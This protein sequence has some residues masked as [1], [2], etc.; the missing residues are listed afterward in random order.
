[1]SVRICIS[2]CDQDVLSALESALNDHGYSVQNGVDVQCDVAVIV[3]Q[4]WSHKECLERVIEF[5]KAHPRIKIVLAS[6]SPSTEAIK[7]LN[8]DAYLDMPFSL[9]Q[10]N[11]MIKKIIPP[12]CAKAV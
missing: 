3:Y 1:M 2:E 12:D 6:T 10:F 8:P 11:E 4:P 5:R 7:G 9:V